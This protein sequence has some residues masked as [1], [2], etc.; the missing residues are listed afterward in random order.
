MIRQFKDPIID[1]YGF[2]DPYKT[3][4]NAPFCIVRNQVTEC[5]IAS[6]KRKDTTK[7][8]KED[9][10][11]ARNRLLTLRKRMAWDILHLYSFPNAFGNMSLKI[12]EFENILRNN[13]RQ[14]AFQVLSS[15]YPET[16]HQYLHSAAIF[17]TW[18]AIERY[19]ENDPKEVMASWDKAISF[20]SKVALTGQ[21]W[22]TVQ[23]D[24]R[25][26][27][28]NCEEHIGSDIIREAFENYLVVDKI[29]L[30]NWI[31][32]FLAENEAAK[33]F[34]QEPVKSIIEKA[35]ISKNTLGGR[36]TLVQNGILQEVEKALLP[37]A[38]TN[39]LVADQLIRLSSC[40]PAWVMMESGDFEEAETYLNSL[41]DAATR[42]RAYKSLFVRNKLKKADS[43]KLIIDLSD[44]VGFSSD[45]ERLRNNEKTRRLL[46]EK[47]QTCLNCDT[48][49]NAV[50]TLK[51]FREK[52][53]IVSLNQDTVR[54]IFEKAGSLNTQAINQ[55]NEI[56]QPNQDLAES[57][58][59]DSLQKCKLARR[60]LTELTSWNQHQVEKFL[61]TVVFNI[62]QLEQLKKSIEVQPKI[63]EAVDLNAEA[64][65]Q[66]NRIKLEA[67]PDH[68]PTEEELKDDLDIVRDSL[69]KC[70]SA[71]QILSRLENSN[72]DEVKELLKTIVTNIEQ[73]E[74]LKKSIEVQPKIKEA[75]DLNAEAVKQANRIKLEPSPDHFPTEEEL[76]DDLDIVRDSLT[77]CESAKQIISRLENS[78]HDEV[79]ELLKTIVT[80]IGRLEDLKRQTEVILKIFREGISSI[81]LTTLRSRHEGFYDPLINRSYLPRSYFS[82]T[83]WWDIVAA[84][85]G[86]WGWIIF[87]IIVALLFAIFGS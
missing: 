26:E 47:I 21:F 55:A 33:S 52:L 39:I 32:I 69:A 6:L 70:E 19:L 28:Y 5:F 80:N 77:K 13:H 48:V 51:L 40:G 42:S 58:I 86:K 62:E 66:A 60:M 9:A 38:E 65:K 20:W 83:S 25:Y 78:N 10:A 7:V 81:D 49:K 85:I 2:W 75:V 37:E 8:G 50:D 1:Q 17:W 76:K 57:L 64:V 18:T 22:A 82:H 72:H 24:F 34:T 67:S 31:Y 43:L 11:E 29:S 54:R 56:K 74:Q 84:I 53:G 61:G 16:S 45:T 44:K 3:L 35:S 27:G 68:C 30:K 36:A 59:G 46:E 79:K 87:W 4:D 71:K 15:I 14:R 41:D 12:N 73:L 63:K 23:K